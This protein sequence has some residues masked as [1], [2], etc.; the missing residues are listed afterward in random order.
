MIIALDHIQLAMPTGGEATAIAFFAGLLGFSEEPKPWP[1]AE[2]G[3]CWFASGACKLR[4][5]IDPAFV[6][7]KKAHPAFLCE[8]IDDLTARLVAIGCVVHWNHDL[9]KRRRFYT[10]DPFGNRLELIRNGD[11]FTQKSNIAADPATTK[12]GQ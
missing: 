10:A 11:G 6:P 2:R 4:I 3:G 9:P 7:Q 8:D 5:G 1:L 12:N